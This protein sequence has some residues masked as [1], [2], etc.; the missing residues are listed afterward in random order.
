MLKTSINIK[1]MNEMAESCIFLLD[2]TDITTVERS[3]NT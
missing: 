2:K 3:V 1:F